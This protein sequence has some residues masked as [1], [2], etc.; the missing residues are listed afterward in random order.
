MSD[1]DLVLKELLGNTFA[2]R[3][4]GPVQK[5]LLSVAAL[6]DTGYEVIFK[7]DQSNV[8]QHIREVKRFLKSIV[9]WQRKP[10][11]ERR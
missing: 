8:W 7:K 4:G 10:R 9:S 1:T 3:T 2:K 11:N 5:N 6:V